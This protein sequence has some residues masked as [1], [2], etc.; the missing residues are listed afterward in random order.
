MRTARRP[1]R[2]S[3]SSCSIT[4]S[5]RFLSTLASAAVSWSSSEQVTGVSGPF[6]IK[7]T[8]DGPFRRALSLYAVSA[9]N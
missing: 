6:K 3:G 5:G 1:T 8:F 7:I 2:S 9:G 4:P